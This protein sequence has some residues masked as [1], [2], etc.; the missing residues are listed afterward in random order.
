MLIF[1]L[2]ALTKGV[3]HIIQMSEVG[4]VTEHTQDKRG[5]Q[6]LGGRQATIC[7][8]SFRA[9]SSSRCFSPRKG[10]GI[11]SMRRALSE[12]LCCLCRSLCGVDDDP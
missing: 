2:T 8:L 7:D 3:A 4:K 5:S 1:V 12:M 11:P 10:A 6:Y 9:A